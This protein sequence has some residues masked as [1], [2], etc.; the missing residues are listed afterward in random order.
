MISPCTDINVSFLDF[1]DVVMG[2]VLELVYSHKMWG[3]RSL[4]I[5]LCTGRVNELI[6]LA[7]ELESFG[8][9]VLDLVKRFDH[10]TIAGLIAR[11]VKQNDD[12]E[13]ISLHGG[14]YLPM[15]RPHSKKTA[16]STVMGGLTTNNHLK[17]LNLNYLSFQDDEA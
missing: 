10:D 12:L 14:S 3:G 1:D 4:S 9:I 15:S 6:E 8:H 16:C 5:G 2:A 7:T 13:E 11:G 17:K